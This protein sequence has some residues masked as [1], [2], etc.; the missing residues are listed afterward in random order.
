PHGYGCGNGCIVLK[1]FMIRT[2]DKHGRENGFTDPCTEH[3]TISDLLDSGSLTW[4]YYTPI[5][6]S[7]WTAPL[8]IYHICGVD[9]SKDGSTDCLPGS[10][11]KNH[12]RINAEHTLI[13]D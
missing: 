12:G 13:K 9:G 1:G 6:G 10:I 11:F 2:K 7:L 8:G 5:E 3:Q 4:I